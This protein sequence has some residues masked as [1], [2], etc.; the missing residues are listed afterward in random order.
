MSRRLAGVLFLAYCLVLAACLLAG[1]LAPTQGSLLFAVG[2]VG[3]GLASRGF[4]RSH[5]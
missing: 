5:S 2:L 4:R 3:F 1:L